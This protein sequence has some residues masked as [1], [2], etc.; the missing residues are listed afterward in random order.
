MKAL[1]NII[2]WLVVFLAVLVWRMPYEAILTKVMN[3]LQKSSGI[4]VTWKEMSVGL[5]GANLKKLLVTVPSGGSFKADTAFLSYSF[6]GINMSFVQ[7]DSNLVLAQ[8]S[9]GSDADSGAAE[10][11]ASSSQ[12]DDSEAV[13]VIPGTASFKLTSGKLN[14]K[15][16][17]LAFDTGSKDLKAIQLS[18]HLNFNYNKSEGKGELNMKIPSLKGSL[19]VALHNIEMGTNIT[20]Q[21]DP[22]SSRGSHKDKKDAKNGTKAD[23]ALLINNRLTLYNE[24]VTGEGDIIMRTRPNG[25]S[26]TLDGTMELKT[27]MFGTQ[28]VGV[29]GTWAKPEWNLAGAR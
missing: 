20:I 16:D 24:A 8:A 5:T 4:T 12:K 28:K 17:N 23:Q 13:K 26:P 18:G 22:K 25:T 6:S 2:I 27:K 15:S 14:F 11:A 7:N 1:R 10:D 19:P 3:G 29:A 21:P 9:S